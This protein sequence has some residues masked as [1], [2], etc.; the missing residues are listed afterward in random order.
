MSKPIGGVLTGDAGQ[1]GGAA[2]QTD[3]GN[4]RGGLPM[5][6]RSARTDPLT[7]RGASP[8]SGHVRFGARFVEEDQTS[9]IPAGLLALPAPPRLLDVGPVLFAGMECFSI[10]QSHFLEDVMNGWQCATQTSGLAQ[11]GQG[12]VRLVFQQPLHLPLMGRQDQR[13]APRE[14]MA[15]S[16]IAG[17]RRCWR[18]FLTKPRETPK[19]RAT[20]SRLPSSLS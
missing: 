2:I 15:W 12:Q 9:R 19:C 16:D 7:T 18:S 10:C 17:R 11:F 3:G 4:H 8:Q 20:S 14:T 5:P 1:S 6:G 13:L